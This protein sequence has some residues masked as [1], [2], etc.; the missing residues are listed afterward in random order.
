ML[1]PGIK[2]TRPLPNI[3]EVSNL[4]KQYPGSEWP[5]VRGV[6]FAVRQGE[7]FG[8]LGPSGAGKTTTLSM[9]SCLLKPTRGSATVAG[10]DVLRQPREIKRRIGF[11]P[12]DLALHS[13]LSA[14]DNLVFYGRMY[15]LRG[16]E[17][18]Q[19]VDSVLKMA[20]LYDR[21]KDAVET[22]SGGMKR[23]LS[24]AAAL[25]HRP[26]VLFLDEPTVGV[27]PQSRSVI[28]DTVQE[29]KRQG[30][31]V[32]YA[33][34]DREEAERLCDRV[35]MIDQGKIIALDT[36]RAL[37]DALGGGLIVVGLPEGAPDALEQELRAAPA[38]GDAS[39]AGCQLKVKARSAQQA[40]PEVIDVLNRLDINIWSLEV[41]EPSLESAF[42][43]LTGRRLRD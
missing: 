32:V 33:T 24:V 43:E 3:V 41:L 12:Q 17:L 18:S 15:G 40:L 8:F 20:G 37:R 2:R 10:F 4:V 14:H 30:T 35:A 36:P 34:H 28:L 38:V 6:S 1:A 9:L 5:A 27:D 19:R 22:Y 16:K 29:L 23:R 7:I 31:T 42:L 21:R 13:T 11:V 26:E 39:R 25:L